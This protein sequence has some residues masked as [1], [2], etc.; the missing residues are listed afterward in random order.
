L[1]NSWKIGAASGLIAG[2][3]AGVVFTIFS[4][5]AIS[6]GLYTH[7][8]HPAIL[9]GYG[10]NIVLGVI[11]GVICGIIYSRAYGVIPGKG[12]SKGL[13]YGM[14]I[15]LISWVRT[16]TFNV[17]YAHYLEAAGNIFTGFFT[18]IAYSLV[19]VFLYEFLRG[20][21]YPSIGEPKIISYDVKSGILPGAIAG[22]VVSFVAPIANAVAVVIGLFGPQTMVGV[23]EK[24]TIG[25][26]IIQ[27]GSHIF[28]NL[29][30]AIILGMIF[31]KVY[32]I[33]PGKRIMKGLYFGLIFFLL[34][35]FQ[36]ASYWFGWGAIQLALWSYWVGFFH[37]IAFGLVLGLLYRKP[38]E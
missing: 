37:A 7:S 1:S 14:S 31:A 5:I 36:T 29:I 13:F 17:A 32:N 16:S 30:W 21:Y 3:L 2:F 24:F 34:G 6:I 27:T 23:P 18:W 20:R 19:L 22:I 28:L 9:N 8:N 33:V 12:V 26:W 38:S 15:Y 10:A 25:F 35:T 11:F 4:R